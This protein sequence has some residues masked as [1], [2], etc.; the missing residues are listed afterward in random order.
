MAAGI[1]EANEILLTIDPYWH[2]FNFVLEHQPRRETNLTIQRTPQLPWIVTKSY[3]QPGTRAFYHFPHINM[4][5]LPDPY[6]RLA[7][8]KFMHCD[9]SIILFLMYLERAL[10]R[11]GATVKWLTVKTRPYVLFHRQYERP[12]ADVRHSVF[13]ITARSGNQYIAD[14]TIEQFGYPGY[15]WFMNKTVYMFQSQ[16]S[17]PSPLKSSTLI[18]L[19][20]SSEFA[21]APAI[22]LL[23]PLSRIFLEHTSS[24]STLR[25]ITI[26]KWATEGNY[27]YQNQI[28]VSGQRSAFP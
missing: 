24:R 2:M 18:F 21:F 1:M 5:T 23:Q 15:M 16:R 12:D 4:W 20:L 14:F 22:Q 26:F 3:S 27:Q 11:Y 7:S 6:W 25:A 28:Q 10:A 13:E 9:Y 17:D 8:Y 19:L